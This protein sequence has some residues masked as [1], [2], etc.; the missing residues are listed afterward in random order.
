[1]RKAFGS[2]ILGLPQFKEVST[3]K[4]YIDHQILFAISPIIDLETPIKL[5]IRKGEP[6]GQ[7]AA[8]AIVLSEVP[9]LKT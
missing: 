3:S 8:V 5:E 9:A 7:H 6:P 2:D 1:V 4:A